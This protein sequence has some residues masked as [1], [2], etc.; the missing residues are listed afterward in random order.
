MENPRVSIEAGQQLLHYRLI[1]KDR[2]GW[3]GRGLERRGFE[4]SGARVALK[5][6]PE[7]VAADSEPAG[8]LRARGPCRRP[9]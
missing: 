5:V 2:R 6:L 8:T 1:E 7:G 3:N 4:A 9:L